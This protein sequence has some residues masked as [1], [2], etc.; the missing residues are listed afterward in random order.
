MKL[1]YHADTDSLY[2]DLA[3]R[4]SVDSV[5]VAEGVVIDLDEAGKIVG[6]DIQHASRVVDL[7]RVEAGTLPIHPASGEPALVASPPVQPR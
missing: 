1:H 2:I 3:D 4:A 6:L 7:S 5:E